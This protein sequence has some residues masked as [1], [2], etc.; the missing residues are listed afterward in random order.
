MNGFRVYA[1]LSFAL[2]CL[3][4]QQT[5][6]PM[7]IYAAASLSDVLPELAEAFER[8]SG[9]SVAHQSFAGSQIFTTQIGMGAQADVFLSASKHHIQ[10]LANREL[11]NGLE[12]FA[13]NPLVVVVDPNSSDP[14]TSFWEMSTRGRW[15]FGVTTSPIGMYTERALDRADKLK[16]GF[17]SEVL[18]RVL[19]R[20][21]NTRNVR[22]TVL[23][24][25]A[26]GAIVYN[27]DAVAVGD[28]LKRI[29]LPADVSVD[30]EY[31]ATVGCNR[32]SDR[33][34]LF[35]DFLSTPPARRILSTHG[36]E[37]P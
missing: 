6:T 16:P 34:V 13:T 17:K 10:S 9:L 19:S 14:M 12:R 23:L 36:F 2:I 15:T 28:R 3:G 7:T 5:K 32:A 8:T 1:L 21:T 4:C 35:R 27:T 20:T 18:S 11:C 22:N 25:V 29:E 24:K 37:T 26:D 33:G 31:F 30:G